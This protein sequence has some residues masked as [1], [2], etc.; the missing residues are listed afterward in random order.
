MP[1]HIP[2]EVE[3]SRTA[4]N[5]KQAGVPVE[6]IVEWAMN[7]VRKPTPKNELHDHILALFNCGK[8]K[9]DQA[10]SDLAS[11][12]DFIRWKNKGDGIF[13]I[14]RPDDLPPG[15]KAYGRNTGT[16]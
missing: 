15:C 2:A 16:G 3:T 1:A 13:M 5:R 14:G 6:V 10:I 4:A 11:S 8:K 12:G 7:E 9:A